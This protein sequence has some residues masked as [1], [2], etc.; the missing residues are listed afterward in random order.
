[1]LFSSGLDK[2]G[3]MDQLVALFVIHKVSQALRPCILKLHQNLNQLDIVFQ[4]WI[5]YFDIL[6]IL[7]KKVAEVLE[8]FLYANCEGTDSF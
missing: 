8:S 2:G 5:N 1:M 4:L 7:L 3:E 6:F